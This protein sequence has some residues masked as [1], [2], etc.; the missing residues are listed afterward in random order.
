MVPSGPPTSAAAPRP[1][2]DRGAA[3]WQSHPGC[4]PVV[5]VEEELEVEL[6]HHTA[7]LLPVTLHQFCV[8]HQLF[9][10]QQ[11]MEIRA[12]TAGCRGDTPFPQACPRCA[13][14][15]GRGGGSWATQ[16]GTAVLQ[17]AHPGRTRAHTSRLIPGSGR[18]DA[19]R[20]WLIPSLGM[21]QL[22]WHCGTRQAGQ[23][24]ARVSRLGC[25]V[26]GWW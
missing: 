22:Q 10:C 5:H 15:G 8:V 14:K 1:G 19:G 25:W 2:A 26:R 21:G 12:G 20:A 9:L 13:S 4:S 11:E 24:T 7:D 18:R 17:A 6:V 16:L 3:C 23:G